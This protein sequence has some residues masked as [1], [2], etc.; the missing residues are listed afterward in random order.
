MVKTVYVLEQDIITEEDLKILPKI[1]PFKSIEQLEKD[2]KEHYIKVLKKSEVETFI[3][4]FIK[5]NPY[6]K[7]IF[8][9]PTERKI[10]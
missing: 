7:D 1:Y 3:K 4:S 8:I 9:E 2:K 6:P 10:G 5:S